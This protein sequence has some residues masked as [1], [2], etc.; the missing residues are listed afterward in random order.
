MVPKFILKSLPQK[1]T[2]GQKLSRKR[3]SM[4]V[5]IPDVERATKIRAKYIHSLEHD[6]Y[7]A[8]PADVYVRGFLKNYTQ[9]L[10]L[11]YDKIL[12]VYKRERG[13]EE[14]IKKATGKAPIVKPLKVPK[15]VITPKSIIISLVV[16]SILAVVF[17]IGWQFRVFSA[18]PKLQISSPADN[19]ALDTDY[20]FIVGKTDPGAKLF[21]ND[22]SV[23]TDPE[24]NFKERISLSEGTN[25]LKI[26]ASSEMDKK[27]EVNLTLLVKTKE[28]VAT[29]SPSATPTPSPTAIRGL[30]LKV[31]VGPNAAWLNVLVDGKEDFQ[32]TVVAG[33]AKIFKAKESIKI[34]SGN[35]TSTHLY[36]SN[37]KVANKDLGLMNRTGEVETKEF[38]KDTIIP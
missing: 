32:G 3:R 7:E 2:L 12:D 25:V 23:A 11:D 33:V 36:L 1:E 10:G 20:T 27:T 6:N 21:I 31:E 26:V 35:P 15:F 13:I 8:L 34:T 24:G 9:F 38:K 29:L 5:E 19:T 4:G 16:F 22:S 18:P 30:E 14:N 28:P 37:E 17:Y